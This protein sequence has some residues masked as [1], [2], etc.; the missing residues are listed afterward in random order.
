MSPVLDCGINKLARLNVFKEFSQGARP[1]IGTVFT[2]GH[3][4]ISFILDPLDGV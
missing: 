2:I 1:L 4:P 3:G